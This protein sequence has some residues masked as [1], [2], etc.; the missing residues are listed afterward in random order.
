MTMTRVALK[1]P[2]ELFVPSARIVDPAL[3]SDREPVED[4]SGPGAVENTV[5]EEVSTFTVE[6]FRALTEIVDPDTAVTVPPSRGS[7][8]STVDAARLAWFASIVPVA[9]TCSPVA[10]ALVVDDWPPRVTVVLDDMSTVRQKPWP[11]ATV[12]VVSLTDT[13]VPRI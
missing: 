12:I 1:L 2:S 9:T 6:P 11:S 3:T 8:M 10:M 4:T 5:V 7:W 13:T